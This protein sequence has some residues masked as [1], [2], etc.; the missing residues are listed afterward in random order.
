MKDYK[1]SGCIVTYNNK[2]K[3]SRTIESLL[4]YTKGVD[5]E[6]YVVDNNSTDGTP[7]F[8]KE[9]FP[10]VT[11]IESGENKG[12]GAG[13]NKV[14]AFLNSKYHIVINPDII[15]RD[16]AVEK[17]VEFMDNNKDVGVVSPK[18]CFPDGR[19]QILGKRNPH[20]KYLIAS[21]MR[22]EKN[23]SKLLREYAMLDCDLT[24][25]TDID[26]ATG[27]F[28]VFRTEIFKKLKGFD[29]KFFMYFEDFDIARRAN[30]ISRVVFY[31]DATIYHVWGRES[32]R[33][34]KLM[35]IHIKSMFRYFLKW[36][37]I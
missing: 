28:V 23:P 19:E 10:Q 3:I 26:V 5:F 2:D 1:V 27:C 25:V 30:K 13:H 16:N 14:L 12:F 7:Q 15:I 35:M 22:D 17:I 36:K 31:P 24:K 29:Q 33:N 6:L 9:R 20:L 8:I 34:M 32:K 37:T 11:V 4:E 18:I 21:R